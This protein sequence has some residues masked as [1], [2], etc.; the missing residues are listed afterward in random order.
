MNETKIFFSQNNKIITQI[1]RLLKQ[2]SIK[3]Y[4][5]Y[6]E[7]LTNMWYN[8]PWTF[9]TLSNI[10][11]S[12]FQYDEKNYVRTELFNLYISKNFQKIINDEFISIYNIK[13]INKELPDLIKILEHFL[14]TNN[15]EHDIIL[16]TEF[17][18]ELQNRHPFDWC[19]LVCRKLYIDDEKIVIN[20]FKQWYHT[21]LIYYF[22]YKNYEL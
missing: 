8:K 13:R 19:S 20:L 9:A 18:F 10:L 11:F 2:Y 3:D 5:K 12:V 17:Q 15:L 6:R 22:V 14:V 7:K 1:I 16:G 21:I 4:I